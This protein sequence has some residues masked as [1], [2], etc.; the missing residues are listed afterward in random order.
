MK[1]ILIYSIILILSSC[2]SNETDIKIKAKWEGYYYSQIDSLNL[3]D[4]NID[5]FK[6]NDIKSIITSTKWPYNL[7]INWWWTE[8][9]NKKIS[10]ILKTLYL[11][12]IDVQD[13][14]DYEDKNYY[15]LKNINTTKIESIKLIFSNID[16]K[17]WLEKTLSLLKE[18]I[19]N[20]SN[21]K[22]FKYLSLDIWN[23][24]FT[25]KELKIMSE[26]KIKH[27]WYNDDE[28]LIH[29]RPISRLTQEEME[30]VIEQRKEQIASGIFNEIEPNPMNSKS[31]D[32]VKKLLLDSPYLEEILYWDYRWFKKENWKILYIED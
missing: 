25:R 17:Q 23:Y 29:E 11:K 19:N 27:F 21:L 26:I 1:N 28:E 32:I 3:L 15:V 5:N 18:K 7:K 16:K 24:R 6:I 2:Q 14:D 10:T 20:S 12:N 8:E 31:D 22:N 13:L 4:I 9:S 30:K